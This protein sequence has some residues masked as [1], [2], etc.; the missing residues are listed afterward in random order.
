MANHGH[1]GAAEA[2]ILGQDISA[3]GY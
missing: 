1:W 3:N 2:D